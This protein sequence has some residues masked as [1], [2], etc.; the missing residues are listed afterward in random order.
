MLSVQFGSAWRRAV[1]DDRAAR[2]S[3]W[4]AVAARNQQAAA[5]WGPASAQAQ[6]WA[7]A[8]DQ[9]GA[10]DGASAARWAAGQGR[11]S[12]AQAAWDTVP[13]RDS[14]VWLAWDRSIRAQDV[15][16]RLLYNPRPAAR[17]QLLGLDHQSCDQYGARRN[18]QQLLEASL[19]VPGAAPLAF[20]FGGALY[21]PATEPLAFFDFRYRPPVQA[22]QPVDVTV[23][24][25]LQSAR[26]IERRLA[27]PWGWGRPIDPRPTS[28]EY[29]DYP[30]PVI[31]IDPPAEPEILETYMIANTVSLVVLPERTPLN[32]TSIRVSLDIDSF[33]WAVSADLADSA[34]L[35]L[36]RPS[37]GQRRS[38]ELNINGWVFVFIV[39][40]YG[41]QGTFP[42]WR[43]SFSGA[44]RTQLLGDPYAPRRSAVNVAPINARQAA[45][46]QLENT[47]FTLAWDSVNNNPPDWTL[48]PGALSYQD[49]T[50]VQVIARI[51][52]AVGGVVRP[53]RD[54]DSLTVLSRYR[55][56][57]WYWD[58]AVMDC[59]LPLDIVSE[60]GGEYAPQPQWNSCYVSG[61]HQGV[62]VDVRRAGTAGELPAPDVYDDLM[63]DTQAGRH[64]G[65]CELSK[66]GEQELVS[67]S[68]PLFP[69]GGSAPGLVLPAMLCEVRGDEGGWRGLCLGV[70]IAAEGVGASRVTQT[71]RLERHMEVI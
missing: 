14:R 57:V 52:E 70:E 44:S 37:A 66:G 23:G 43:Y 48:P 59:I 33:S 40:R 3:G 36:V 61:T 4:S 17:D 45:E 67:L 55:E 18:P 35:D 54:S 69:V 49:Q 12:A 6:D 51:A 47:G 31:V 71:V 13:A 15:R 26:V 21:A 24:A 28:I 68:L 34:S 11:D 41:R 16:L 65:I 38:V 9:V 32:A 1:P 22:I 62:A 39:E 60:V 56:A 64:R 30:G 8:W 63:T 29:P 46:A 2:P 58:Q 10:L 42:A 25:R 27:L 53:S 50:P 19:Y 7:G 20:R 5:P